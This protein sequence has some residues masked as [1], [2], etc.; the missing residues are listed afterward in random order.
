M[1]GLVGLGVGEVPLDMGL[2]AEL[3]AAL[4]NHFLGDVDGVDGGVGVV[5]GEFSGEQAG[6]GSDIE[7]AG[8]GGWGCP[9]QELFDEL[10]L[11]CGVPV[12]GGGCI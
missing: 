6:A 5:V 8:G 1:G 11:G 4:F 3:L 7:Y 10:E 2:G 12:V 9:L